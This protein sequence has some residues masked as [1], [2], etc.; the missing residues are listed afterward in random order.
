MRNA[1]KAIVAVAA[2]LALTAALPVAATAGNDGQKIGQD[3][4]RLALTQCSN[5]GGGNG[6]E[7]EAAVFGRSVSSECLY[8]RLGSRYSRAEVQAILAQA[9]CIGPV[10]GSFVCEVD[11]G[12]SAAH[13]RA[14]L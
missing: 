2:S 1:R 13:N 9:N 10:L 14:G 5:A 4:L 6:V 3:E 7:I 8:K 12:N 11:P